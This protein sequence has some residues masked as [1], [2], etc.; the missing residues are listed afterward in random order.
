MINNTAR[1]LKDV[2]TSMTDYTD[3][4]TSAMDPIVFAT[5]WNAESKRLA[6]YGM[7][8]KGSGTSDMMNGI[9]VADSETFETVA[10]FPNILALR[11]FMDIFTPPF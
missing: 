4:D 3:V 6:Q 10:E 8:L 2:V 5:T 11:K 1:I 9:I 7:T